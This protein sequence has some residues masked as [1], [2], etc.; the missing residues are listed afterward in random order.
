A[1]D[2]FRAAAREARNR[3]DG[4]LLARAVLGMGGIWDPANILDKELWELLDDA[5]ALL[6][7]RDPVVHV[8]LLARSARAREDAGLARKA[9]AAARELAEPR[10]LL[11]ALVALHSADDGLDSHQRAAV[12]TEIGS[13]ANDVGDRER[14]L[15][16]EILR[17]RSH[18]ECCDRAAAEE[19]MG[20]AV[21]LA[22]EFRL[23]QYAGMSHLFDAARAYLDGRF[24]QTADLALSGPIGTPFD[25]A[26]LRGIAPVYVAAAR[27]EQGQVEE[28]A[29]LIDLVDAYPNYP[30]VRHAVPALLVDLGRAEDAR[31]A[32][33]ASTV[34]AGTPVWALALRAEASAALG[35]EV[36]V[37][38]LY[39]LL[40][41][42]AGDAAVISNTMLCLGSVD[43]YLG[44]LAGSLGR[45][46]DAIR[47][48]E[49]AIGV[50]RRLRAPGELAHIEYDFSK[51]LLSRGRPDDRARAREL[52]AGALAV[53]EGLTMDG[54]AGQV[55][56]LQVEVPRS[57]SAAT[58]AGPSLGS[59]PVLTA[60]ELE[61]LRLIAQGYA[62]KQIA[63]DLAV[64]E[65]TAKTHV[66]NILAKLQVTDRTQAAI[67]AVRNGLVTE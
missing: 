20:R 30:A 23:P 5:I 22:A 60:R 52:L 10:P 31:R 24:A 55:R 15:Q 33:A 64:S 6:G 37:T 40:R 7:E 3:R 8:E 35:D 62:N 38:K 39:D 42:H 61:V 66:S 9:V 63:R 28:L 48:F 46:A 43:R 67:Y 41:R 2:V 50:A 29:P 51:V 12:T 49:T 27:R 32:L 25:D 36:E 13:L 26:L 45:L 65:K 21:E 1:R 17:A 56:D 47:H 11:S 57:E 44:M 18:L 54:L 19:A 34:D 14:Q 4:G 53:A 16:A 58:A 59:Q